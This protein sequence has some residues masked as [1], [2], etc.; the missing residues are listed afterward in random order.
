VNSTWRS[1]AVTHPITDHGQ[2]CV[3][4]VACTFYGRWRASNAASQ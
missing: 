3:T 4:T 1:L 2:G